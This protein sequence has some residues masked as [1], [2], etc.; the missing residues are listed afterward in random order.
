MTRLA[1]TTT[2]TTTTT[3]YA[4]PPVRIVCEVNLRPQDEHRSNRIAMADIVAKQIT[5]T[6]TGTAFFPSTS[7]SNNEDAVTL[8]ITISACSEGSRWGRIWCGELGVGWAV[9]R[10]GWCLLTQGGDPLT[11][12]CTEVF[13]DSG[14]V[15]FQD[16]CNAHHGENQVLDSMCFLAANHVGAKAKAAIL[17][18]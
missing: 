3:T 14:A 9:L 17:S 12:P 18:I 6:L 15:G 13:R 16:L 8:Y 4:S 11:K 1:A 5:K 7:S 10:V 2:T